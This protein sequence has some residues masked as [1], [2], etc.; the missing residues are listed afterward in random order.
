MIRAEEDNEN[1]DLNTNDTL[2]TVDESNN[3][4]ISLKDVNPKPDESN[5]DNNNDM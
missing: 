3:Y 5:E 2:D 4:I 1:Y